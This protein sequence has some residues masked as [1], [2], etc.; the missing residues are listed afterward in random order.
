M[1]FRSQRSCCQN[2]SERLLKAVNNYL[3]KTYE[4]EAKVNKS[5]QEIQLCNL[6]PIEIALLMQIQYFHYML[7]KHIDLVERRLIKGEII[8]H[9]EKVFSIFEPFTHWINKGKSHPSVELGRK[10]I[11]TSDQY[12]L[13]LHH[14]IMNQSVDRYETLDTVQSLFNTYGENNFASLSFDKG[15]SCKE[16]RKLLEL[17]IPIVIMPKKGRLTVEDKLREGTKKFKLL[18]KKHSAIESNINA[19]EHH[20]LNRCPDKGFQGFKRYTA[21]GVLAYNCH[22]IGNMLIQKEK[23]KLLKKAA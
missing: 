8:P 20:G 17:F 21:L 5:I 13:I 15:F 3:Q 22:K 14:K 1:L 9:K 18:R 11:L 7:I 16:D 6:S 19:L 2:K 12:S 10:I 4:L 23:L